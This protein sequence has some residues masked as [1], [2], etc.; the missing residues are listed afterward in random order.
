MTDQRSTTFGAQTAGRA[1]FVLHAIVESPQPLTL[2]QLAEKVGLPKSATYRLIREM[3]DQLLIR[4]TA[5]RLIVPA[6]GLFSLAAQVMGR[7]DVRQVVRPFMTRASRLTGETVGLHLRNRNRRVCVEIVESIHPLRRFLSLGETLPLYVGPSGKSILAFLADRDAAPVMAA[8]A[9]AG[10]DL[11]TIEHQLRSVR[12]HGFLALV[13]DQNAGTA[14]LSVPLFR[15]DGVFATMTVSGPSD[16]WNLEPMLAV[17]DRLVALAAEC[18]QS[19][20]GV[21]PVPLAD[22]TLVMPVGMTHS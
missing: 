4:V 14:G 18:S 11:D 2:A 3:E 8:A 5:D 7:L 22:T 10:V 16:R 9:R 19:L 6:S 17:A 13:D 21:F 1:F 15:L 20:G 12:Q